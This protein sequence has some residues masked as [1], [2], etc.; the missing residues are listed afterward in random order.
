M[1]ILPARFDWEEVGT[2]ITTAMKA[3]GYYRELKNLQEVGYYDLAP[4]SI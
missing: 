1:L 3:N 4:N 2:E